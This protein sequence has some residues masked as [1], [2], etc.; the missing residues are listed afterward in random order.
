MRGILKKLDEIETLN[1]VHAEFVRVMRALAARFQFEAMKAI[2][3]KSTD[4]RH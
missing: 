1:T 3:R 2:L 4:D